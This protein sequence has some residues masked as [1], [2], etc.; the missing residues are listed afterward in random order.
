MPFSLRAFEELSHTQLKP[1]PGLLPLL[2][3]LDASGVSHAIV[4]NAPATEMHHSLGVLKV[5][6]RF[7]HLVPSEECTAGKPDPE[8]Y[9]EGMRRLGVMAGEAIAVED[10]PAG[11]R[12]A[13]AAVRRR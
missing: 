13:V 2:D 7:T 3:T 10:S 6:E 5:K 8:P 9:L 11:I 1:L 12:S 4:T